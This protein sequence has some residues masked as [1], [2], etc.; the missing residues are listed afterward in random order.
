MAEHDL[1]SIA[2]PR[3]DE[4]QM[5]ELERCTGAARKKYRDGEILFSAGQQ[6]FKFFVIKAGAVE[7]VDISG[8]EPKTPGTFHRRRVSLD[9]LPRGRERR[10][11]RGL[12]GVGDL[13]RHTAAALG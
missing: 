1:E 4:S 13:V 2:F 6:D 12:R 5:A 7:I 3:L 11:P 9:R 8:S 10:R